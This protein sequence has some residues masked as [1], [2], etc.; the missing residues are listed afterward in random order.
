MDLI[1]ITFEQSSFKPIILSVWKSGCE[2]FIIN[3]VKEDA[4]IVLG[5]IEVISMT[6]MLGDCL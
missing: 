3:L 4:W 5:E 1:D 6:E 2:V